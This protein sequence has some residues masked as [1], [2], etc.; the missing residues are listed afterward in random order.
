MGFDMSCTEKVIPLSVP[1]LRGNEWNY[2]KECLDTNWVSYVGPFVERFERDLAV[3]A[4]AKHCVATAS[5]TAALH[6]ALILAGVREDDE[7]VMPGTTFVA[8]AN[9]V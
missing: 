4:G 5:G 9:A 7:V 2:V 3:V 8:P 6:I 1:V